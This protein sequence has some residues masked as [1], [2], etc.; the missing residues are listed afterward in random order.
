M[1]IKNVTGTL[2]VVFT[3]IVCGAYLTNGPSKAYGEEEIS[4]EEIPMISSSVQ[5][6]GYKLG[7]GDLVRVAVWKNAEVSGEFRVRPDGMFS[8]PLVGDVHAQG[9]TTNEIT[10][11][12][13]EKLK[14]FIESPFVSTIVVEAK[15]NKFYVMGE[16]AKPGTYIIEGNL[17]V[18]QALS[19]A[20][21]F[22][23]FASKEKMVLVRGT[24]EKQKNI[25]LSYSRILRKPGEDEN[26]VLQ[27]GDTLVIP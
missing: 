22:T 1:K 3:L 27:R 24:G 14:A 19:M 11:Q 5:D 12:V 13:T 20:G 23:T 6:D 25:P 15:S 10:A 7:P 16:V 2:A 17:T 26:P 8:M 4:G 18:L 9:K 21:G